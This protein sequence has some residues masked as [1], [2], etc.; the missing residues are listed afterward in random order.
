MTAIAKRR[1][2]FYWAVTVFLL[3]FSAP[4]AHAAP[5]PPPPVDRAAAEA[6]FLLAYDHFIHNRVWDSIDELNKAQEHNV[7]FV[8]AYYM[9]A[10]AYR[11]LGRYPE[12]IAEMAYYLEVRQ[13]DPRATI[14]LD[15][16]REEWAIIQRVLKP[17]LIHTHYFFS[18]DTL[19]S[20]L[21]VPIPSVLSLRGM[22]G[23]GKMS[24]AGGR[25]FLCDT[26]GDKL[27]GFALN[28]TA[29]PVA[30]DVERPV[31]CLPVAPRQALLF[32]KDGGVNNVTFDYTQRS[33][34]IEPL[35]KLG[36]TDVNVADAAFV[37]STLLAIAD[38][39]G[40]AVRFYGFPS[41]GE[42]AEWRPEDFVT[43]EKLFEPV[44]LATY[45]PFIAIADRTNERVYIVDTYTLTERQRFDVPLPRDV[46][47]G[48]EGDLYVLS[49]NGT[50]YSKLVF[51]PNPQNP[52]TVAENMKDAWCMSWT[53]QGP[54]LCDI[55]GRTWWSSSINPGNQETI[56]AMALYAPWVE[57]GPDAEM[58]MIR[59]VASSFFQDFIQNKIPDTQAIWRNELRPSR[60]FDIAPTN[61][62]AIRFYSLSPGDARTDA[63]V[64]Q[65]STLADVMADLARASRFGDEIPKVLVLD[66][67]IAASDD[68]LSLFLAFLMQ[69]GIRLDLWCIA[70]P[71]SPLL[72]HLSKITLGN[73]YYARTL[74][75]VRSNNS[76]EWVLSIPLPPDTHTFGYPSESTLS[77]YA[78]IDVIRFMDWVPIWPSL[79][80]K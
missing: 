41:L 56:G 25:L 2:I 43:S 38:R 29:G 47:W 73:T 40:Q 14:I 13:D 48:I 50:L 75:I 69:Q 58:L 46:E 8:D 55:T 70:R 44:S 4:A 37:D 15:T 7:Y 52:A 78:T 23:L 30:F 10:L 24:S 49:E 45:G 68:E 9:R 6:A 36:D 60:V 57:D 1:R 18:T 32:Q 35:G 66:T 16:M 65:A 26:Y 80:K 31:I 27:W 79:L 63:K 51:S 74:D 76:Y 17:D 42:T 54:M 20:I 59:V 3:F 28:R 39:T 22:Q 71:A 64:T 33:A 11:R 53:N 77:I 19:H 34:D 21:G 72:T 67:R 61:G 12:A 62:G 5:L